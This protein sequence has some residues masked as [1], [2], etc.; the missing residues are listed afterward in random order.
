MNKTYRRNL[1]TYSTP[2]S[3]EEYE[4]YLEEFSWDHLF[5]DQYYPFLEEI[6]THFK[7]IAVESGEKWVEK[8]K[9]IY[10]KYEKLYKKV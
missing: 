10:E 3:V 5:S 4:K 8:Y 2:I 7:S 1:K 9:E 6:N